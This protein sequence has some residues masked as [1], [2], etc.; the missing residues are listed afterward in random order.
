[1][2]RITIKAARVGAFL[3]FITALWAIA[4]S[5]LA[6]AAQRLRLATTTSTEASGLL[7]VLL[8]R[9]EQQT[10]RTVAVIAVG[11]GKALRLAERGDVDVVLVHAPAAEEAFVANGFGVN[12]RA[13]MKNDFVILG[14]PGDPAEVKGMRV[15]AAALRKIAR[16]GAPFVSR[17]DDSGTHQ[18]EKALWSAAAIKPS[19][20]WYLEVG[21]GMGECLLMA[22]EKRAYVLSDRGTYLAYVSKLDLEVVVQGDAALL[23]PYSVIAVNPARHPHVDYAGAL[24]L[25][26]WLTSKQGQKLIGDFRRSGRQLFTPDA[27]P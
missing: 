13:V 19:G 6:T 25:I 1:M 26:S 11:T 14:P 24:S 27:I 22:N 4:D 2:S 21:M 5:P 7:A 12:R 9:F 23:N 10:G 20:S 3:A 16:A 18:R 15:V 8:P 17:G